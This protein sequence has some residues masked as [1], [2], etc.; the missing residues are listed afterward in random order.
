MNKT[1]NLSPDVYYGLCVMLPPLPLQC[2]PHE[3]GHAVQHARS[4]T[5]LQV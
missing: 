1:V 4:Y 5:W 3:M 2:Q